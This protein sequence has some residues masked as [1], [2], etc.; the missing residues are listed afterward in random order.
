M[1]S[2]NTSPTGGIGWRNLRTGLLFTF[3]VGVAAALGL[4]I[5]KNT[6]LLTTHK[7]INL[8]I[9]DI[10]GLGE[11][12]M[13]TI[14]G[15][16]VGVVESMFFTSRNDTMGV[17]VVLD[18]QTDFMELIPSDSR[19]V[20]KSLGVL[21]DRFID[22]AR[23]TSSQPVQDGAFID[24]TSQPGFDELTESA[25][26]TMNSI[27]EFSVRINSGE[28]SLGKLMSSTELNDRLLKTVTNLETV[29]Q[30]LVSGKGV[31]GKLINDEELAQRIEVLVN[32]LGDVSTSLK[33]GKGSLGK[34]IVDET[35][36]DNLVTITRKSDSLLAQL[37]NP[38]G[39]LGKLTGDSAVYINL[40]HSIMSLDSLL[41][42][43]KANPGRYV[44][45]SVF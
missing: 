2:P 41:M 4:F 39:T 8:F 24:V 21:G 17:Q 23:G 43:L 31:A 7:T 44:K 12:N 5:G 22:I 34:L 40:N 9:T 38:N 6:G 26:T 30:K 36:Y 1:A 11:G 28:G 32:N 35:F 18:V 14:S 10:K 33:E 20:I 19:A 25:I 16:K 13:V 29:T 15:K 45:V 27:E 3:G 37:S 42:D